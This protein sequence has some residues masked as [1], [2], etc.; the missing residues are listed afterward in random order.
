MVFLVEM[1]DLSVPCIPVK[2]ACFRPSSLFLPAA[3]TANSFVSSFALIFDS[4]RFLVAGVE[5]CILAELNLRS[6]C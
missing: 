6:Q 5:N 1:I 2:G 4:A 3:S